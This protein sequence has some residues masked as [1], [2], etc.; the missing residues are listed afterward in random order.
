MKTLLIILLVILG[1]SAFSQRID[2]VKVLSEIRNDIKN[3][4]RTSTDILT[5]S[6]YMSLHPLTAF[7]QV[8][9]ENAPLKYSR[10]TNKDEPG[11]VLWVEGTITDEY[12]HP[13][14]NVLVYVYHTDNKGW[15]GLNGT[16][17]LEYEGDRRHARLFGYVRTDA[18][19]KFELQTIRPQGYPGSE[20][21]AHIH[22]EAGNSNKTL[23]TEFL[24][25][26]D[27]RLT[28]TMRKRME[29]EGNL[30]SDVITAN[31]GSQKISYRI[32]LK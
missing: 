9:K 4:K 24:F 27:S 20:L 11:I 12:N 23:I 14:S 22:C 6:N 28:T 1:L 7:R 15:Y 16:H 5:D 10:L 8:I 21:P 17:V 18:N 30:F 19:G 13:L 2:T 26:D 32:T 31:N 29:A 3:N 25:N